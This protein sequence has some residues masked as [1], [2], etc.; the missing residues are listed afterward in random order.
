M[1][2]GEW[3]YGRR[4]GAAGVV[5]AIV[6]AL[7]L[8]VGHADGPPLGASIAE[9]RDRMLAQAA[10]D[11]QQGSTEDP[12]AR[13]RVTQPQMPVRM[14]LLTQPTG[15]AQP[16][17]AEL[18]HE[19]PDPSESAAIFAERL[20]RIEATSTEERV[21]IGYKKVIAEAERY[22]NELRRSDQVRLTLAE[23][24]QR[25]LLNN[26]TI[27]ASAYDP[28]IAQTQIVQ[29]ESV[30]DLE[31]FLDATA[32]DIDRPSGSELSSTRSENRS[33]GGGLRK[34]LPTGMTASTSLRQNFTRSNFQFQTINPSYD[35]A[36]IAEFNQPL[37][38]GFGLDYN[39]RQITLARI[40]RD[41]AQQEFLRQV[42]DTLLNVETAYWQL[43]RA[44]R[45]VAILAESVAQNFVTKQDLW[46]RREHDATPVEINNSESRYQSRRVAYLEALK[47]VR[48]AEDALKN[49]LNDNDLLLSRE[50]E[51]IPTDQPLLTP[52]MVDQFG[53]VRQALDKRSEI[54]QAKLAIEQARVR[55]AAAKNE[56]LPKLDL[57]FQYEVDGLGGSGDSSF[58]NLTTNRFVSYTIGATF[59]YPLGNRGPKAALQQARLEEQKSVVQLQGAIDAV[60]QEVNNAVR[61]LN[62]R[63]SQV[64]PQLTAVQAADLNLRALQARTQ[65]IDPS[66]LETELSG[67]EQLANTRRSL[68]DVLMSYTTGVVELERAKG[69]LLE[70]NNVTVT[71]EPKG[72]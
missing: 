27:R 42:R 12:V 60:V 51:I 22:L 10:D 58:D 20:R 68:L 70:Y 69:T 48:D 67:V 39:R 41:A 37:L 53:E 45:T 11:A 24:I 17:S 47:N 34:L 31:F 6:A 25:A 8:S 40:G 65:R 56:T 5:V 2:C 46:E 28:A 44:R 66:Y 36:F 54:V 21:S 32:A 33:I 43:A 64:P 50:V 52:L 57:Q 30:F 29:A 72:R 1:T 15:S 18:L 59:S 7:A 35:T 23:T 55:T 19:I 16:S 63:W 62:V 38:R 49:L 13:P 26:Y 4:A 9:Y 71:D 3:T 14:A 61:T